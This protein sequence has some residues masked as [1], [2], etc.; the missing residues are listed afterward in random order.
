MSTIYSGEE[1]PSWAVKWGVILVL[2][3]ILI[4]G[5]KCHLSVVSKPTDV[6]IVEVAP[7][8]PQWE[9]VRQG[10]VWRVLDSNGTVIGELLVPEGAN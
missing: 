1:I 4:S 6:E 7:E 3:L 10:G 8:V 2:I 9:F 5:V